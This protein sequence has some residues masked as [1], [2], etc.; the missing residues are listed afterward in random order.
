MIDVNVNCVRD[1]AWPACMVET[2]G[3]S[4]HLYPCP[5]QE[6]AL[7]Q[8]VSYCLLSTYQESGTMLCAV[9][10][11]MYKTLSTFMQTSQ[12]GEEGR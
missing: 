10:T 1:E 9:D 3:Q 6:N 5:Q 2:E 4:Q 12:L 11:K 7:L 8:P